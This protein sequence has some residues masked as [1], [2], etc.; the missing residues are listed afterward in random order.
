MWFRSLIRPA[1]AAVAGAVFFAVLPF[2]A[3]AQ[4]VA[5]GTLYGDMRTVTQDMLTRAAGDGPHAA[6][7][8]TGM[9]FSSVR[10]QTLDK[11]WR[12]DP[13]FQRFRG[14]DWMPEPCQSCEFRDRDLGG[15]RC[16][17]FA[18]VGDAAATDPVCAFS[19][20]H[21]LVVAMAEGDAASGAPHYHH[22]R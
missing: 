22:R 6:E 2:A 15:C 1:L 5:G 16:Q 7:T 14:T 8:I 20:H 13:A 12:Q 11:I 10:D 4:E 17:A 18:I 19:P 21:D 3:G 9:T